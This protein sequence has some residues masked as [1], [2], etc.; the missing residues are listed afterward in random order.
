MSIKERK[1]RERKEMQD[2]IL[3]AAS[4]I[5]KTEGLESISIRKIANSI[6]Y[7]PAIIYHYFKNKDDIINNL[8]TR[9]YGKIVMGLSSISELEDSPEKQLKKM[10]GQVIDMALQIPEEYKAVQLS[11]E[12]DVLAHT[13]SLYKGAAKEKK[14]LGILF[15]CLKDIYKDMDDDM[16]ELTAQIIWTSIFGLIIKLIVEKDLSEE[17]RNNLIEHHIRCIIDGMVLGKSLNNQEI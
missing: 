12:P 2:L 8:M 1:E 6:D 14:A 13:A 7:S 5:F 17:Q 9:G 4:E 11:S 16:I 15:R 10:T 3:N